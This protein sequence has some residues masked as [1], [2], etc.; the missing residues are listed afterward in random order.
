[1]ARCSA[2]AAAAPGQGARRDALLI[3]DVEV[4]GCPASTCASRTAGS[5]RSG[6]ACRGSG[7][8]R[9]ARRRAD[10]GARRPSHPH[11]RARRAG[12]VRGPG[13]RGGRRDLPGA[14]PGGVGGRPAG[15]WLRVTGY[16]ETMAGP[17]TRAELDALAPAH[18]LRVQHQTGALW[19][20]NS[21]ALDA[22][23][24]RPATAMRRA[25]RARTA[26]RP[27][28]ARRRLAARADRRGAAGPGPGGPPPGPPRWA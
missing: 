14:D 8:D 1:M 27:D 23:A 19:V 13:R 11:L 17:L 15:A 18:R 22:V 26:H 25:R 4:A 20:L 9:R 24:R 3:R 2:G 12:P 6:G 16:H 7:R 21:A 5:P 28:L 10:P